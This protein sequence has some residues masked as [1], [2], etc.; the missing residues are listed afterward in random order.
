MV[1]YGLQQMK[2]YVLQFLSQDTAR[3]G[4]QSSVS[5]GVST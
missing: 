4:P 2:H 3:N 5:K 1:F